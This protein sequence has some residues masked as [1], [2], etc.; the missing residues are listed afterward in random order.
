MAAITLI[1]W[2]VNGIRA[3][4]RKG[5]MQWFLREKPEMLCL[6][7]TKAQPDQIPEDLTDVPGYH[8]YFIA[9]ERKGYSGVGLYSREKPRRVYGGFG[10]EDFDREGRV[11]AAEYPGFTLLNIYYP[12][13]KAS[14]ERLAYKMAFYDAFLDFADDMDRRGKNLV[15]C[16]DV[17]TAHTEIDLARPRENAK[18]SGFLPEERAWMDTFLEHGY[19]DTLRMFTSE[20]GLY[21]WWDMKSRARERNVGWRIDYVF[22][23]ERF[24][25]HV[26]GAFIRPEI[27][28]SD[29]CPV[30]IRLAV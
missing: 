25:K 6:Q 8:A 30:G 27:M 22:V 29:H 1:S 15:I 9:A 11:L 2:N 7:E 23:N 24:R 5:A 12:N 13:G 21:S 20:P 26:T 4:H 28:G 19:V 16:G 3:V 10:I 14:P 17:N 18:V